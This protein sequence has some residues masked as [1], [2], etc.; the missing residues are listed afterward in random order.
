MPIFRTYFIHFIMANFSLFYDTHK[1]LIMSHFHHISWHNSRFFW[2]TFTMLCDILSPCLMTNANLFSAHFHLYFWHSVTTF[3]DA[4]S[5]QF[6]NTL[7]P[8]FESASW[9][10][11]TA[12][13][14]VIHFQHVVGHNFNTFFDTLPP[15][16][17]T[18]FRHTLWPTLPTTQFLFCSNDVIWH[19]FTIFYETLSPHFLTHFLDTLRHTFTI[20]YE[21]ISPHFFTHFHHIFWD[22]STTILYDTFWSHFWTHSATF[23]DPLSPRQIPLLQQCDT[24][25][26]INL[27]QVIWQ[28]SCRTYFIPFFFFY[29]F[30][31][32]NFS[33]VLIE[34]SPWTARCHVAVIFER[35]QGG[36]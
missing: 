7:S 14:K 4:L 26:P 1:P 32:W 2:H 22:I 25:N 30:L 36:L 35:F 11:V 17:S 29:F 18:Y 21:T 27:P 3:P 33:R 20:F 23:H 8:I 15:Y 12:C 9:N 34:G 5:L 10:M 16:F 19:T 24:N 6:Y 28:L 31:D 13:Q